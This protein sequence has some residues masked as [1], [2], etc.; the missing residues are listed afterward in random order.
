MSATK[1][2]ITADLSGVI[3][4]QDNDAADVLN[5]LL[6]LRGHIRAGQLSVSATDTHVKT[7][8]EALAAAPPLALAVVD[9]G[10][11]ESLSLTLDE[12]ALVTPDDAQT[13]ANKTL[14][15]A[16]IAS[17]LNAQHDH[18]EAANGG[19]LDASTAFD[20]GTIPMARLPVM[21]TGQAGILPAPTSGDADN[22]L[23]GAGTWGDP[24]SGGGGSV[25]SVGLSMPSVLN[26]ANSPLTAD[27]T[28]AVTNE[29]QTQNQ[30]WASPDGTSGAPAF[31]ALGKPDLPALA[32]GDVGLTGAPLIPLVAWVT[33]GSSA[34][35]ISLS[36]IPAGYGALLLMLIARSTASATSATVNAR[37]NG[38]SGTN[39]SSA[40]AI[41]STTG[42]ASGENIA[43]NTLVLP[44]VPAANATSNYFGV[45]NI[46]LTDY[47]MTGRPRVVY[48]RSGLIFGTSSNQVQSRTR[49]GVWNNTADAINAIS[50]T[51][52]TGDFAAGTSYAL[53]GLR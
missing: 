15:A 47:A 43:E 22:V 14:A 8:S 34:G 16:V 48:A 40:L 30:V 11:D 46:W 10:A 7:L 52:S 2:S 25:T 13:L 41:Y 38:D 42:A 21:A 9:S 6:E 50:L 20:S 4:G 18:S 51:L 49:A 53:F 44:T 26:V 28:F 12:A 24:A 35:S 3:D 1:N 23:K 5:P 19:Q 36:S 39:Y 32:Y 45:A 29:T 27:G 31:R 17:F 33:L 37:F